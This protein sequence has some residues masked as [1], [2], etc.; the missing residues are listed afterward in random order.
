CVT[1]FY[2]PEAG[3]IYL[4]GLEIT[5]LSPDR[6]SHLGIARTYQNIRLFK[7][8]TAIENIQ[9]G[10][11]VHLKAGLLGSIVRDPATL[12]EEQASL[13]EARRLLRLVG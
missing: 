6:I 9:V 5:G 1:G 11:H 12:R 8:M 7:N 10:M 13:E 4:D 2:K 3:H